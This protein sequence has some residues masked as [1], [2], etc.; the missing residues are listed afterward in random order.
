M[1]QSRT[2][3]C[4]NALS[5]P[6]L[7]ILIPSILV[8]AVCLFILWETQFSFAYFYDNDSYYHARYF[9]MDSVQY[10]ER[11]FFR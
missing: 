3:G 1:N 4:F 5:S 2:N 7:R 6:S 11:P 8:G 9:S 10:M